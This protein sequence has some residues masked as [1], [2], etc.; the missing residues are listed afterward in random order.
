M[1]GISSTYTF[2]KKAHT[3]KIRIFVFLS[4]FLGAPQYL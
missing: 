3:I 1:R 4:E 2:S